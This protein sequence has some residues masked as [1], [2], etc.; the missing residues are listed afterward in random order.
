MCAFDEFIFI[1]S[2]TGI[3]SKGY[4]AN[5]PGQDVI[6]ENDSGIFGNWLI[7]KRVTNDRS[8]ENEWLKVNDNVPVQQFARYCRKVENMAIIAG[9]IF[10]KK[11]NNTTFFSSIPCCDSYFSAYY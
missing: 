8:T 6:I 9:F 3:L 2:A 1:L 10:R 4:V 11:G 7:G 5:S